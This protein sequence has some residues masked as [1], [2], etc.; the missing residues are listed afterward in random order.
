MCPIHEVST[1]LPKT[2][3]PDKMICEDFKDELLDKLNE[4]RETNILCDATIR[5]EGQ[6]FAA[7]N[8]FYVLQARTFGLYLRVK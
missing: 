2:R 4:L 5:T 6:D 3:Y 8:V 7:T 1:D